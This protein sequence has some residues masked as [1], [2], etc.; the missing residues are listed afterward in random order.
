[1]GCK[2]RVKCCLRDGAEGWQG[3]VEKEEKEKDLSASAERL[4]AC[5]RDTNRDLKHKA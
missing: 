4:Q 1:M 5:V 3:D 2:M